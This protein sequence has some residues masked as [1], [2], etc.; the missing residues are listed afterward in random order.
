MEKTNGIEE[1]VKLGE[2]F[3]TEGQK[4]VILHDQVARER[5]DQITQLQYQLQQLQTD[6][7]IVRESLDSTHQ[8]HEELNEQI[9]SL[10]SDKE[11]LDSSIQLL[12]KE[13]EQIECEKDSETHMLKMEFE[14]LAKDIEG[15]CFKF[16]CCIHCDL[17]L[18]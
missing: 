7:T 6:N 18:T 11:H 9:R 8:Q 17:S 3:D 14:A 4:Y 16:I 10:I 13:K 5:E 2:Y 12:L 1:I 15:G